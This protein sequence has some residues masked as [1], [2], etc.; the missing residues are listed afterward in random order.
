MFLY[1]CH[2]YYMEN[3]MNRDFFRKMEAI[4]E[5]V[6]VLWSGPGWANY[7]D[8]K[9]IM[10]NI[11]KLCGKN[12][13][14]W[15]KLIIMHKPLGEPFHN[16]KEM[17]GIGEVPIPKCI[18]YNEMYDVEK[19]L[20]EIS[21][22]RADLIVCHHKNEMDLYKKVTFSHGKVVFAN[23]PHSADPRIFKDYKLPKVTDF[24]LTG[25]LGDL[26]PLRRRIAGLFEKF[27]SKYICK[28]YQHPGYYRS[29]GILGNYQTEF[30][31]AINQAKICISCSGWPRTR[32]AKYVEIPMS[33]SVLAADLPNEDKDF[34]R[35]FV[36]E[37]DM[38]M[39]DR[40]IID[41]L[42]YHIEHPEILE[43]LRQVGMELSNDFTEEKYA[44][45]FLEY[46]NIFLDGFNDMKQSDK[47]W[48]V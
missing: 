36:I 30:A 22:S 33:G 43:H 40:E 17:K 46:C 37:I 48:A 12:K 4:G 42:I 27:P 14:L 35:K 32:Y 25:H 13:E 5:K 19:I 39:S 10:H 24:L 41:K 1:L 18:P 3:R 11:Y 34:F 28:I 31:K 21:L 8:D 2:R 6:K 15:P 47:I 23:I 16:T 7:N 26:Y 9:S 29:D 44:D 20:K 45:R 38:S